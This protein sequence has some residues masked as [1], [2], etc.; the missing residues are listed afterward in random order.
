MTLNDTHT[1]KTDRYSQSQSQKG[2]YIAPFTKLDSSAKQTKKLLKN[3]MMVTC[4][5]I[6]G[7]LR[8]VYN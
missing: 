7:E 8:A 4:V 2:V 6:S 5:C 1:T 3:E